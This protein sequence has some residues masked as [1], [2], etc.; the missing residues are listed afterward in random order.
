MP[1]PPGSKLGQYEVREL[2]GAGGMG[3]VYRAH[4]NKLGRD[5]AIKLLPEALA[6]DPDRLARFKREAKL[7]ASLNHPN[8]AAIYGLEES[9]GRNFLVMELVPGE[10]LQEQIAREG[11][12]SIEETVAIGRQIAEALEH[13]QKKQIVHRDLKPANVKLT[14]EGKVKVL[15]FGLAKAFSAD[16]SPEVSFDSNSPTVAPGVSP[17]IPGVILGTAAYMSPE[18]AKGKVVDKRTDIWALGCV[19]YELLTARPAFSGESVTEILGSVMRGEPDWLLLPATTPPGIRALLR[20]CLQK[21]AN[22]RLRGAADIAIA[23]EDA[24]NSATTTTPAPV[25]APAM[26]RWQLAAGLGLAALVV[27]I[28]TWFLKPAHPGAS[29]VAAHVSITLPPGDQLA[30]DGTGNNLPL[31]FSPDGTQIAYVANRG[32]AGSGSVAQLFLRSLDSQ[33]PLPLPGTE[34]AGAP[35]FSPDGQWLGFF[36]QGKLKKVSVSG[37]APVVLCDTGTGASGSWGPDDTIVFT[38]NTSSGLFRVPASGGT[39]EVITT[40]DHA[41]GELSHRY[42]QFLPGGKAVLFTVLT[43]IGW[44]EQQVVAQVLATGERHVLVR[45]GHTGRYVP[46]GNLIYARAGVLLAVPFDL[47]RLEVTSDRPITIAEGVKQSTALAADYSISETGSLAYIVGAHREDRRLVWVDRKGNVEALLA[48]PHRYANATLSPNGRELAVDTTSNT[49]D[50]WIYDLTRGTLT[51]ISSEGDSQTE[52]WTPDGKR[53]AYRANRNGFRN[54]YWRAADGT[55]AEERLTKG[56]NQQTPSSFSPDGKVLAFEESA[57]T[58]GTDIWLLPMEGDRKPQVFLQTPADE[59]NPQFSPDGRWLAYTSNESGRV[60]VYLQPFPGPGRKWQISTNGGSS[61]KWNPN[62]RELFYEASQGKMMA[63]D[64]TA[65][66]TFSA[67]TP[68]QLFDMPSL[69]LGSSVSPDGQRFLAMQ[70][71]ELEQP[72]TEINVVLNW[73]EELKAKAPLK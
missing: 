26:P 12:A 53:V 52:V 45:G 57:P 43:G 56:E 35:F 70:P 51:K 23:L 9:E 14:P 55:G 69:S 59:R 20:R 5:V 64:I 2:I 63:V 21:D 1:L 25:A 65:S 22:K 40:L 10:T 66:P 4:D 28:A 47:A 67:G 58:S 30:S 18:Q 32:G 48:A 27:A 7:L 31:A 49:N 41:K 19:L 68:H 6:R 71:V 36:A 24:L 34:G 17:T 62:G 11:A 37:G 60:E 46:T 44:D 38:P 15:D 16:S 42:P 72:A 13:A 33:E 29:P 8:I 61:P 54:V 39:P 73:S 50:L 3:E